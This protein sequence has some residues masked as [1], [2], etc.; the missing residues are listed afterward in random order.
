V[1][2]VSEPASRRLVVFN[3]TSGNLMRVI[4]CSAVGGPAGVSFH[5]G[6]RIVVA[7]CPD[8]GGMGWVNVAVSGSVFTRSP[9]E[10]CGFSPKS[11]RD[12][13]MVSRNVCVVC[14]SDRDRLVA[15]DLVEGRLLGTLAAG[16]C[17]TPSAVCVDA[18]GGLWVAHAGAETVLRTLCHTVVPP[19]LQ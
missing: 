4:D 11:P 13:A 6:S 9:L 16:I 17:K 19:S 10:S 1:V 5:P 2:V 3:Y 15:V 12:V 18:A 7:V 8:T 14:D